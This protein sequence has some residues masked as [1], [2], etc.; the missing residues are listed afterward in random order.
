MDALKSAKRIAFTGFFH[1]LWEFRA[2]KYFID[3]QTPY[4]I[5]GF[6]DLVLVCKIRDCCCRIREIIL[7]KKQKKT[8][9]Y[10]IQKRKK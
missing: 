4:K 10:L 2:R 3:H 6:G 9:I 8:I 1:P 7:P 5:H